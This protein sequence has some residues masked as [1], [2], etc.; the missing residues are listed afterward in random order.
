V[1]DH[2]PNVLHAENIDCTS[3]E[4]IKGLMELLSDGYEPRILRL[5]VLEELS[6]ITG[7]AVASV[8]AEA[9][10]GIFKC[11]LTYSSQR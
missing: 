10:R 7:L 3:E 8:L 5:H 2:L 6:P 1:L 9:F 4:L 11:E